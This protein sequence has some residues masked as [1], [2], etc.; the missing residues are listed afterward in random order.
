[1]EKKESEII[2]CRPQ[3]R[4]VRLNCIGRG[5]FG[6]VSLA[7]Y[8][9]DGGV[10]AV[11]SVNSN[12]SLT[13]QIDSLENEIQIV[14]S[15]SSPY[16]V[17]YLGDDLT[18]ESGDV[19]CRNLHIEYL[20]GGTAADVAS[21]FGRNEKDRVVR[22][23]TWCIVS[24]LRYVHAM[25]FVH[26]DVKGKNVL[27]GS[28]STAGVAKLAD[29][30]SSKPFSGD[31]KTILP[32]G[33]PLW[34]A[35]EVVRGEKQG[36]ESDVWSLGCT[37]IEMI[38]GKPAWEDCGADT[39][40]RIAFSDSVPEFPA[41]LSELGRDFI[42]KC[43]RR[44][45]SERWTCD[46]LLHHPFVSVG[47]ITKSSPRSILEWPSSEFEEEE[48]EF[49]DFPNANLNSGR[50]GISA[51]DRIKGLAT[52][53][54]V[55]WE[56]DGWE[57]VRSP[58]SVGEKGVAETESDAEE[59]EGR[60]R[61]S[62]EYSELMRSERDEKVGTSLETWNIETELE[63]EG[64]EGTD[65]DYLDSIC[66]TYTDGLWESKWR[67]YTYWWGYVS[68]AGSD[69]YNTCIMV[70]GLCREGQVEEGRKLIEDRWGKG[71]IPNVVFYNTRTRQTPSRGEENP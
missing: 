23:F 30:G 33:S 29:F 20:Q 45:P 25:D 67:T 53:G 13:S 1:M 43:L 71:C 8:V 42:E 32:R 21:R 46:Q 70:R 38:T 51:N 14:K 3:R 11:K 24:A 50:L 66:G 2:S 57:L 35:P 40:C 17:Q 26:C 48:D 59:E 37:V 55:I 34:M 63:G 22:S 54:G 56:S 58:C 65:S 31:E 41:E 12:S 44:E 9:S 36:P 6:T 10:F 60:R 52:R 64:S 5:S 39:L 18:Q 61:T 7:S 28:G 4:W 16:V 47:I 27:L 19:S 15:L 49:S 62:L 68:K 69:N